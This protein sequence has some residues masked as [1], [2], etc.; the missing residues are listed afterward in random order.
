MELHHSTHP[1]HYEL[2]RYFLEVAMTSLKDNLL[3]NR[4]IAVLIGGLLVFA[5]MSLTV[6]KTEKNENAQLAIALDES[7]YEAGRLLS[8]AKAQLTNQNYTAS[9]A[10]L[11]ELLVN[12]PGSTEA[13]EGKV[14]LASIKTAE[15]D[16]TAKWEAALP[17]VKEDWSKAMTELLRANSAKEQA[18]MEEGLE[19]TVNQA[20][21]KEKSKIQATWEKEEMEA[22]TIS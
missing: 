9:K 5:I 22:I 3:V 15:S 7:R 17:Q 14:L 12:Q 2:E 4:I 10:S 11:E 19:K 13:I 21:D 20:W 16:A 1:V 18:K 8:D 6:V